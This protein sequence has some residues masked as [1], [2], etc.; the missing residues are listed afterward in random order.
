[1]NRQDIKELYYITAIDNMKSIMEGGILCHR[2]AERLS[3]CSIADNNVQDRRK[4]KRIP[5]TNKIL[6]DFANLYFDAH[7]PMLS[8]LREKNNSICVL[9]INSDVFDLPGVIVSDRNAARNLV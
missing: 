5:G 8:R 1:M 7:N 4:N 2:L 6:H 9:R 3:H